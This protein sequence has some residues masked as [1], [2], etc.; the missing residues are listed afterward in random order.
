MFGGRAPLDRVFVAGQVGQ[1]AQPQR[2][3]QRGCAS[4]AKTTRCPGHSTRRKPA[5]M[6]AHSA[7][8]P[9]AGRAR[10]RAGHQRGGQ[11]PHRVTAG[12]PQKGRPARP[13]TPPAPARRRRPAPG[14]RPT[15][16]AP[17]TGAQQA[18][19]Q[20]D[21]EQRQVDGH[22]PRLWAV[23]SGCKRAARAANQRALHQAAH[24]GRRGQ[25][26]W[27]QTP[28]RHKAGN[29]P[30]YST[31][32]QPVNAARRNG[33]TKRARRKA[34][35]LE[36]SRGY[37]QR[38]IRPEPIAAGQLL[39]LG[40]GDHVEVALDGMLQRRSRHGKLHGVL[41]GLAAQQRVDQAAAEAVAAA[42]AVDDA[43]LVLFC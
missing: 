17:H 34:G 40:N 10:Q 7:Q 35:P 38:W 33:H 42:D 36:K 14:R 11:V 13:G 28:L 22:A 20:A 12:A 16:A 31:A 5:A 25:K 37:N 39:D 1:H 6:A 18:A 26:T 3:P 4:A 32:A 29:C 2:R 23:R 27:R 43:Q 41:G 9:A 24:A 15:A 19:G 30:Q 8:K 21:G